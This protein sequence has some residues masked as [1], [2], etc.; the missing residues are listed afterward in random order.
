VFGFGLR[1]KRSGLDHLG[2]GTHILLDQ[3]S[4]L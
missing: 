3:E 2:L 1:S 4:F